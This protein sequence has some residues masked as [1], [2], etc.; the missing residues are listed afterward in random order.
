[1]RCRPLAVSSAVLVALFI[2]A[3]TLL[4][5]AAFAQQPALQLVQPAPQPVPP[6]QGTPREPQLVQ[7]D[8]QAVA[9]LRQSIA[10]MGGATVPLNDTVVQATVSN[11][12]AGSAPRPVTIKTLGGD[13]IRWDAGGEAMVVSG[14]RG[15]RLKGG[16]WTSA[17]ALNARNRRVEH[18]PALLLMAE[19]V[20]GEVS[21]AYL[22]E[23]AVDGRTT[24][25][26]RVARVA[27]TTG[28]YD[29]QLTKNS[30]LD[31]FIDSQTFLLLKLSY[32]QPLAFDWREGVPME[33]FYADY[34]NVAGLAIPFAQ[35]SVL[36]GN[37]IS[38]LQIIGIQLNTGLVAAEFEGR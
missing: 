29:R 11:P 2:V 33:V 1:M 14:G 9:I 22:G 8:P 34:R 16:Q 30:E 21:V 3:A 35:R 20:R 17:P 6:P 24:K 27:V 25:Q 28:D 37:V 23:E 5:P 36:N 32:T 18:I 15:M 26:V 12:S 10:A 19:L 7:R 13:R 31:L 4:L 38:E